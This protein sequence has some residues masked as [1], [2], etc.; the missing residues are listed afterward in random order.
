QHWQRDAGLRIDHL[1]LSA[2]LADHLED[3]GV[4]R[5]VRGEEHASD[6]A[7]AWVSL[8]RPSEPRR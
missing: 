1:L 6:H 3:A 7:P 5:W 2:S 4:D 8:R